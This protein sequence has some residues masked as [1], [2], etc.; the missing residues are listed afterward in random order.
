MSPISKKKCPICYSILP[1]EVVFCPVCGTELQT[2]VDE[3][4]IEPES[5]FDDGS[6]YSPT[7][8]MYGDEPLETSNLNVHNNSEGNQFAWK[9]SDSV[10][11]IKMK[12]NTNYAQIFNPPKIN[13]NFVKKLNLLEILIFSILG[14]SSALLLVFQIGLSGILISASLT[15]SWVF[16]LILI[17]SL[18]PS[19][20]L[21]YLLNQKISKTLAKQKAEELKLPRKQII[22]F[23]LVQGTHLLSIG[24]VIAVLLSSLLPLRNSLNPLTLNYL[25]IILITIILASLSPPFRIAKIFAS[26]RESGITQNFQ[27]SFQFPKICLKR[28][29]LISVFSY[30]IPASFIVLGYQFITNLLSPLFIPDYGLTVTTWDIV[31]SI[32][33]WLVVALSLIFS[34]IEDVRTTSFYEGLMRNFVDPPT[35]KWINQGQSDSVHGKTRGFASFNTDSI[36]PFSTKENL[37][38]TCSEPLVDGAEFCTHCGKKIAG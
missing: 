5:P 26:V 33:I 30:L 8:P 29:V 16:I 13:L 27:D 15:P 4:P 3:V 1:N 35:L 28:Y 37:C 6:S 14:L 17:I 31:L 11:P 21:S 34:I 9:V 18:I 20:L 12:N 32:V 38:S 22:S 24:L 19:S 10:F 36:M 2:I 7:R 25:L 23:L